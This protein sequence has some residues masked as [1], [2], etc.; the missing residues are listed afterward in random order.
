M[1][2]RTIEWTFPMNCPK[3]YCAAMRAVWHF[4]DQDMRV[5]AEHKLYRRH[6]AQGCFAGGNV[7]LP[8]P[9]L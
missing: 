5:A 8:K 6:S 2:N 3:V 7:T 1:A 4:D 9:Q